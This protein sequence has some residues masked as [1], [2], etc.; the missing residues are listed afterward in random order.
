MVRSS[1]T[2]L[3]FWS[4]FLVGREIVLVLELDLVMNE[5]QNVTAILLLFLSVSPSTLTHNTTPNTSVSFAY[6]TSGSLSPSECRLL[7]Y[8]LEPLTEYQTNNPILQTSPSSSG[9]Y[10]YRI[11][12]RNKNNY[13][14][15]AISPEIIVNC[16]C[17]FCS[18]ILIILGL[19]RRAIYYFYFLFFMI[20]YK[21]LLV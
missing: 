5:K 2:V 7:D 19:V 17:S 11:E 4:S 18:F 20:T 10:S 1:L 9:N 16:S 6:T 3:L 14:I 8:Q 15:K 21:T 13:S 12:C